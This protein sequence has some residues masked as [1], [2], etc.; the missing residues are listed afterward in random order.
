M[1]VEVQ[2]EASQSSRSKS[3]SCASGLPLWSRMTRQSQASQSI[4]TEQDLRRI[5]V[6]SR[7]WKGAWRGRKGLASEGNGVQG[8]K[9]LET[10]PQSGHS[11]L[12]RRTSGPGGIQLLRRHFG[13]WNPPMLAAGC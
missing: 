11:L 13:G 3:A 9:R 2:D 10:L 4:S 1:L 6:Q 5:L 12:G 8:S 7:R